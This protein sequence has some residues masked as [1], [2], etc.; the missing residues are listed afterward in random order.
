MYGLN[1]DISSKKV[2]ELAESMVFE[3]MRSGYF[4]NKLINAQKVDTVGRILNKY[5]VILQDLNRNRADL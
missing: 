1:H 2:F 4:N 3:L 5:V